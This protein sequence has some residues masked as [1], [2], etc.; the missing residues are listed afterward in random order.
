MSHLGSTTTKGN[1]VFGSLQV[2]ENAVAQSMAAS[3]RPA[4]AI[5]SSNLLKKNGSEVGA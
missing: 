2:K 3:E 1:E 5:R 4:D